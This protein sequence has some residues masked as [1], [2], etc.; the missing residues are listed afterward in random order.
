MQENNNNHIIR[1]MME[2]WILGLLVEFQCLM[3]AEQQP[4][5]KC[6]N[7]PIQQSILPVPFGCE[8]TKH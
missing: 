3:E 4:L 6:S 1:L 5:S 2:E 8:R 7:A